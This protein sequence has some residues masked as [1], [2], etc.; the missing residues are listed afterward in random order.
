MIQEE[1]NG[2]DVWGKVCE[3]R[4]TVFPCPL[5]AVPFSPNLQVFINPEVPVFL[6]RIEY[7]LPTSNLLFLMNLYIS[8]CHALVNIFMIISYSLPKLFTSVGILEACKVCF[9]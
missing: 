7:Y 5:R 4:P 3:K 9:S 2:R 8:L 6:F 1:P